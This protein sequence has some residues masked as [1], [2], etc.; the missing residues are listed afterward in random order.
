VI[1]FT[2]GTHSQDFSLYIFQCNTE[3]KQSI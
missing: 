2:I 3:T 1:V